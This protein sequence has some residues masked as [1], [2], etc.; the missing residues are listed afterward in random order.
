MNWTTRINPY[1]GA[2]AEM[3]AESISAEIVL[4]VEVEGQ[5][6]AQIEDSTPLLAGQA[7]LFSQGDDSPYFS[8][9]RGPVGSSRPGVGVDLHHLAVRRDGRTVG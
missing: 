4:A 7:G 9:F 6:L 2:V 8:D 3:P 5:K 1:C